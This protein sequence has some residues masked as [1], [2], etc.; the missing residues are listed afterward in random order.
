MAEPSRTL[1]RR[2]FLQVAGTGLAAGLLPPGLIK[3]L[4][5]NAAVEWPGLRLADLPSQLGE[6]LDLAPRTSISPGGLLMLSTPKEVGA[7]PMVRTVWNLENCDRF[8]RLHTGHPW[9]I[10]L[11][12]FG[13]RDGFPGTVKS[14]MYGFN[15]LRPIDGVLTRTSTHFLVGPEAPKTGEARPEDRIGLLQT[16]APDR[17]G[18]PFVGAHVSTLD[19]LAHREKRQY[20]VRALYQLSY[21]DPGVHSLLQDFYDGPVVEPNLRTIGIEVCGYDFENEEHAPSVQKIANVV[22]LVWALMKRYNISAMNLLGHQELQLSKPDPGKKFLAL[23]RTLIGAKALIEGDEHMKRLVFGSFLDGSGDGWQAAARYFQFVHDY[24]VMTASQRRV[25]EWE[26]RSQHWFLYD[27]LCG[28]D[29]GI[30]LASRFEL[31]LSGSNYGESQYFLQPGNHEGTDLSPHR[32]ESPTSPSRVHLVAAGE[33][34]YLGETTCCRWGKTAL[35]RHRQPDGAEVVSV[36]GHMTDLGELAVGQRY[37]AGYPLGELRSDATHRNR[38]LHFAVA[39]AAT[40]RTDL[41]LR[42]TVP[43]N[44]GPGWIQERYLHPM[45]YLAGRVDSRPMKTPLALE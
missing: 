16:Q 25:Y 14:Y 28:R 12:W 23:I 29:P 24:L 44:A 7:V 37:P 15:S 22:S 17:D 35:F 30:G 13:D 3:T 26:A 20:F 18:V 6:I 45:A 38:F 5:L 33:C 42:P 27:R 4:E 9:A 19:T 8:H 1:S 10:V 34:L 36:Y 11:H 21:A 41:H 39:Y 2:Q 43:A 40:W 31:P 32:A